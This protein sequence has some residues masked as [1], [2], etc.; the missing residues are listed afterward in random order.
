[1]A[2]SP[3]GSRWGKNVLGFLRMAP[4]LARTTLRTWI[5]ATTKT[6]GHAARS[7]V[8]VK[9]A[10]TTAT[11]RFARSVVGGAFVITTA[12]GR[13]ARIAEEAAFA[14]TIAYGTAAQSA[15]L[16]LGSKKKI[17]ESM[18][19]IL[20]ALTLTCAGSVCLLGHKDECSHSLYVPPSQDIV[21]IRWKLGGLL[22]EQPYCVC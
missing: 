5:F 18:G 12:N 6:D 19:C 11:D 8:A 17:S 20:H 13:G 9:F 21:A 14:L 22:H 10:L 16:K 2:I 3:A 7:A 4:R 15:S 1:M